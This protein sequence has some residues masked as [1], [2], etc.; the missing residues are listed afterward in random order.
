MTR[1]GA[2]NEASTLIPSGIRRE[3]GGH[4][5]RYVGAA[6]PRTALT[7]TSFRMQGLPL[8][9]PELIEFLVHAI[10]PSENVPFNCNRELPDRLRF[11]PE[12]RTLVWQKE[13]VQRPKATARTDSIPRARLEFADA[14]AKAIFAPRRAKLMVSM[15]SMHAVATGGLDSSEPRAFRKRWRNEHQG[16]PLC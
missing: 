9:E 5:R 15:L 12:S 3:S 8:S 13:R 10:V 11:H 2:A 14:F 4:Y 16:R 7:I 6:L 1:I